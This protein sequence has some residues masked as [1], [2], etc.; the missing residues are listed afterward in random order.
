MERRIVRPPK[1]SYRVG[2]RVRVDGDAGGDY[3]GRII[4]THGKLTKTAPYDD[5]LVSEPGVTVQVD[6]WDGVPVDYDM[7][8]EAWDSEVLAVL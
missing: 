2:Q 8:I 7:K 3:K 4:E 1:S 5:T 6:W